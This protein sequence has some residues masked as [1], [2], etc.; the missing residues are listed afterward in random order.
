MVKTE[1]CWSRPSVFVVDVPL[2][3]RSAAELAAPDDQRVAEQAALLEVF[4]QRGARL[5]GVAVL[6]FKLRR[7]ISDSKEDGPSKKVL[8]GQQPQV[9]SSNDLAT[10]RFRRL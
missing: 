5:V 6:D 10:R 4:D 8:L 7:D 2:V 3:E 9:P 1:R